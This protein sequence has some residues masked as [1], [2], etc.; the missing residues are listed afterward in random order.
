MREIVTEANAP[1]G[2]LRHYFPE[3][4]EQIVSEALLMM[5]GVA[6]RRVRR[7][8]SRI[9]ASRPSALLEAI[10][11]DWRRDLT[12][13]D[14]AAGCPLVA[15]A[16]DAASSSESLRLAVADAFDS[17]QTPLV[18]GLAVLG[19]PTVRAERLAVLVLS[20]LEGAIVLSRIRRDLAPLDAVVEGLGPL[21]DGAIADGRGR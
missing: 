21:L 10:V 1:R 7:A 11:E 4:K 9:D 8:L 18:D 13:E 3:G 15:A 16:A 19:V 6:G 17:W 5:G 12:S 20:A 14:Y 2:S